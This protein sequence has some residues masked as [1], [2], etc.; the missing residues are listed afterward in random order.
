MSKKVSKSSPNSDGEV[1]NH[2]IATE[3]KAKIEAFK[4]EKMGG[5]K[6]DFV[7]TIG[8]TD[9]MDTSEG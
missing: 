3:M 9:T 8:A 5:K 2:F 6:R 1:T 4:A 7:D